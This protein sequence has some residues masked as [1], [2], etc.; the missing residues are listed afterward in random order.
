MGGYAAPGNEPV[1]V[2]V[3]HDQAIAMPGQGFV[4]DGGHDGGSHGRHGGLR[5][6]PLNNHFSTV[7]DTKA[8]WIALFEISDSL[9]C[10]FAETSG[11]T[12]SSARTGSRFY[13][14]HL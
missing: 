3:R 6:F 8:Y 10:A 7:R 14:A 9:V 12:G 1:S 2:S 4:P 5:R 11:D 13:C